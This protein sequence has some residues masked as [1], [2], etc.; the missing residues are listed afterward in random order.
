VAGPA[1]AALSSAPYYSLYQNSLGSM[2]GEPGWLCPN[3][4]FYDAGLKES[5]VEVAG[6]AGPGAV[7]ASDAVGVVEEYLRRAGR[8]DMESWSMSRD[9]LPVDGRET[10]V[11]VQEGHRYFENDGIIRQLEMRG[12]PL[13]ERRVAGGVAD[14][15]YRFPVE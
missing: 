12:P 2:L 6:F 13:R 5:V 11:L 4:E 10:W 9:G 8:G 14:R 3:D 1:W 15:V 7:V